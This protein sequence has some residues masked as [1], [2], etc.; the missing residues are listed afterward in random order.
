MVLVCLPLTEPNQ[1]PTGI[2]VRADGSVLLQRKRTS[3]RQDIKG[4]LPF[5]SIISCVC[6]TQRE[7]P[8]QVV[9][10]V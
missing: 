7:L 6:E 9:E 1:P 5:G 10:F 4:N 2:L 8:S 3:Q